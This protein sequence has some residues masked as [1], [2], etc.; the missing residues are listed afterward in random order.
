[1]HVSIHIKGHLDPSWQQGLEG[2][3]IV[4]EEN[5]TSQLL[6]RKEQGGR[7]FFV[8]SCYARD[9]RQCSLCGA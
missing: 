8:P 7:S 9:Q 6:G 4:H 1:M 5:G 3:Q 2:L